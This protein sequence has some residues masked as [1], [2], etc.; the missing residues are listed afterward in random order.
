MNSKM[1]FEIDFEKFGYIFDQKLWNSQLDIK[2]KKSSLE[3]S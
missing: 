3:S 2:S 1:N